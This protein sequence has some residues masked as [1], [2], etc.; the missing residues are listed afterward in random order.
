M[1]L[2]MLSA[3]A[4][5][6]VDPWVEAAGIAALSH[7]EATQTLVRML[8]GLP[9]GPAPGDETSALASRLVAQLHSSPKPRLRPTPST[10]A[11]ASPDE[12][13]PVRSFSMLSTTARL[14]I[15]SL[16]ALVL[17][18]FAFQAFGHEPVI[19]IDIGQQQSR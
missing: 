18:A 16:A 19:P 1:H 3:L 2:T 14:A 12:R 6:G 10:A 8:G 17:V 9:N 11:M 4:R 7:D 13:P 5:S 15:Y